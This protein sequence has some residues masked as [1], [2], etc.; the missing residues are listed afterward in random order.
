MQLLDVQV[1]DVQDAEKQAALCELL[2]N[3]AYTSTH[4]VEMK[5][6]GFCQWGTS[7]AQ[8]RAHHEDPII[9]DYLSFDAIRLNFRRPIADG[10]VDGKDPAPVVMDE[11]PL[12]QTTSPVPGARCCPSTTR[13]PSTRL[14]CSFVGC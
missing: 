4:M 8:Q 1:W 11:P 9:G 2:N 5:Q 3:S 14:V 13:D 7:A 12:I 6:D 10:T